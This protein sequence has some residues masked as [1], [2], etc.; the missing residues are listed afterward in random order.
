M[1]ERRWTTRQR[2]NRVKCPHDHPLNIAHYSPARWSMPQGH[3]GSRRVGLLCAEAMAMSKQTYAEKLKDPRWQRKRLEILERD[4]WTCQGCGDTKSTLH[5]HHC[6]YDPQR[7]TEPWEYENRSLRTLCEQCHEGER[8]QLFAVLDDLAM[9][10]RQGGCL[11]GDIHDLCQFIL[12]AADLPSRIFDLHL[13]DWSD[14]TRL[15][16]KAL[17]GEGD[18]QAVAP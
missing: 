12:S 3:G 2:A 13:V 5:V 16:S 9:M 11:S 17:E 8:E 7:K 10:L 14:I 1:A 18:S 15:A 6:W 4:R